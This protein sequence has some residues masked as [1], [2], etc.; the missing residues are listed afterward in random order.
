MQWLVRSGVP[1]ELVY[2]MAGHSSPAML[3]RV[4]GRRDAGSVAELVEMALKKA[5]KG[6]RG[7]RKAG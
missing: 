2:P 7:G 3:E 6:A 4:Y 5:P 1:Y